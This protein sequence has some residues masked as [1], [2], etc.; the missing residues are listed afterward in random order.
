MASSFRGVANRQGGVVSVDIR[1]IHGVFDW[2]KGKE[3]GIIHISSS[4][5]MELYKGRLI[6]CNQL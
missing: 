4:V 3:V 5:N 2:M 6:I 1:L